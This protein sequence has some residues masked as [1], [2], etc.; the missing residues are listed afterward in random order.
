[1]AIKLFCS[2]CG[3]YLDAMECRRPSN[4]INK[5]HR[6]SANHFD[7]IPSVLKMEFDSLTR[8]WI[9]GKR[10]EVAHRVQRL[11]ANPL[12]VSYF[13]LSRCPD[14]LLARNLN[15]WIEQKR[16]HRELFFCRFDTDRLRAVFTHRYTAINHME[17]LTKMLKE[18]E[19]PI[20]H[21]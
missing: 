2:W 15:D 5:V 10:I 18:G 9:S 17:V 12:R 3:R 19:P 11:L 21:H 20:E 14:E 1:M 16:R 13:L 8:I 6:Q 7:E 4:P